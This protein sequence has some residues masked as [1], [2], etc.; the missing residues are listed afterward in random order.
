M[1][2]H[3]LIEHFSYWILFVWSLFEG[4]VGLT[5]GGYLSKESDLIFS[6]VVIIAIIGAFISDITVFLIG[7]YSNAKVEKWLGNYKNRLRLIKTWFKKNVIW[8]ILFERF[9]YGTHIPS[10]LFIGMSGY[11]FWKF[12]IFDIIGIIIW[13]ITFTTLGYYFGESVIDVI[14]LLQQHLSIVFIMLFLGLII[15]I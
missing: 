15:F 9:I 13:A 10:L 6:K 7:K 12:L 5:L 14:M 4:E 1:I 2:T 11:S 3:Y 8:L